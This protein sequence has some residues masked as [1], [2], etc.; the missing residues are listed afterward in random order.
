MESNFIG[1]VNIGSDEMIS[2]NELANMI[3]TISG[4]KLTINNIKGPTGVRGRN[5]DN[6][7]LF[8]NIGWK[9]SCKLKDGI[10]KTFYWINEQF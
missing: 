3:I 10:E 2:I 9:P 5:S 6:K 4:K 7:L 1:P 8:D